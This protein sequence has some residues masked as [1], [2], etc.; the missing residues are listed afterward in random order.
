M[1]RSLIIISLVAVIHLIV[2]AAL[3]TVA[4]SGIGAMTAAEAQTS[5]DAWDDLTFWN[6]APIAA[7]Q[8]LIDHVYPP[9]KTVV[10]TPNWAQEDQTALQ[11]E[12]QFRSKVSSVLFGIWPVIIGT[13]VAGADALF[14]LMLR[15]SR[16]QAGS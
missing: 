13:V 1:R 11:R 4:L 2:S 8:Y 16:S 6:C 5:K 14:R 3:F 15:R 7:N 12:A 10:D 9:L